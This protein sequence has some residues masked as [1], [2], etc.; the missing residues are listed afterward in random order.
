LM[1]FCLRLTSEEM[2]WNTHYCLVV[3]A[4]GYCGSIGGRR[5]YTES[6]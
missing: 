1:T 2:L 5:G 3:W 6:T 4:L